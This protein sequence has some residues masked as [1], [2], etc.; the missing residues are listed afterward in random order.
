MG[1]MRNCILTM[2]L[3]LGFVVPAA[4]QISINPIGTFAS[5]VF[6]DGAAEI[7]AHDPGTQRVFVINANASVVDVLDIQDPINPT[8]LF[9]IDVSV[10]INPNG[11]INSV[12]VKSGIVAVAVENDDPTKNGFVAFYNADGL[13]L[14]SVEVGVLPDA[15]KFSTDGNL[16]I[17]A[18]EGEPVEDDSGNLIEDPKGSVSVIDISSGVQSAFVT[19]VDF[20]GFD[21]REAEFISKGVKL[22]QGVPFSRDVEPEFP[23]ISPDATQAFVTL[24]EANAFAVIDI[25]ES[26][27]PFIVDVLPLGFKDHSKGQPNLR[28]FSF[29]NRPFI[30]TDANGL[31]ITLGGFSGLS[32]EGRRNRNV[33]QFITVPD[34]GPNGGEVVA[35]ARTF[36]LPN[37]QARV[38][39]FDLNL[40]SGQSRIRN[41][42]TVFLSREGNIPITGLP[43]IPGF[44][45]I[46]VDAAGNPLPYDPFGADI[47]G[48]VRDPIDNSF[49]MVDEYRP[50]IYHF[51]PGGN[52]I[53]RLV[54]KNTHLLGDSA[55][56]EQIFGPQGNTEGFYGLENLPEVYNK[57]RGNRGFEA[58]ALDP[59]KRILYAFV[60]S[61]IEN[62]NS[63]TR[64]SLI[65]RILGVDVSD[66]NS[67]TYLKPISEYVYLREGAVHSLEPT[68]RIGDAVFMGNDRFLVIERDGTI[69]PKGKKFIFEVDLKGATNVRGL[70]IADE[71]VSETLEQKTPGGLGEMGVKPVNKTKILNLPSIG[72]LPSDKPE[73][74]ALLPDGEI[75]VLNDN[76]FGIEESQGL[77]PVLGL[78]SFR[79]GNRLDASNEDG[80]INI[81]NWPVFGMYQPDSIASFQAQGMT[82]YTTANEGDGRD[83]EFFSEEERINDIDLDPL[84]F[85][86]A[87]ELKEE[88]NLGRLQI[89]NILGDL[90][91]DGKFDKLFAFGARSFSIWDSFGNL[92]FDSSDDFE[93]ITAAILPE[94][95][96]SNN[97]DND[98]FDS[99]S[100]DK[101]P[102]PEAIAVGQIGSRTFAFIGLERVGGIMVFNVTNPQRP[103]FVQYINNRVFNV[104]AEINGP[105][106]P[107]A[108]DLGPES[109][110]FIP[111]GESPN[112]KPLLVVGN[113]VSGTTTIFEINSRR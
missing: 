55:L 25:T 73:G 50:S 90:D 100:D 59:E 15:V 92:V 84:I 62:P 107:A 77:V 53:E 97:D 72:Y 68:D 8:K 29:V 110:S 58:L 26:K 105:S 71:M 54:P 21:G 23:A 7:V 91:D 83:F 109:I 33:L 17:V 37:Y 18:N 98:S 6:D 103:R 44:D 78:I 3:F 38:I 42:R 86:D 76:D 101:G 40:Q 45:E 20:T 64:N 27:A 106:N 112:G 41:N 14:H 88:Q 9:S 65:L 99:R 81:R 95:F 87:A 5:G 19:T 67:P 102:E 66:P 47:E 79:R 34:R 51:S 94:N 93:K 70:A 36:N 61:P 49:W 2:I 16:I 85:P 89:T 22:Q 39:F 80:I 35:G 24:Q 31:R 56:K 104:D 74:I 57:R 82:F 10:N 96:N 13:F 111:A 113:E 32:F 69:D 63:S 1:K 12:D 48:V 46:P 11:G 52:L 28:L 108:R 30:G 75:V 4:G 43:N 60:Q